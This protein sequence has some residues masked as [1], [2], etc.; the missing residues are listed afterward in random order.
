MY[1]VVDWIVMVLIES[2]PV[3]TLTNELVRDADTNI[4]NNMRRSVP[5]VTQ[6]IPIF[7]SLDGEIVRVGCVSTSFVIVTLHVLDCVDPEA[8]IS[9]NDP[10]TV[11]IESLNAILSVVDVA[12]PASPSCSGVLMMRPL[13]E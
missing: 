6:N 8:D 1:D 4:V 10:V 7:G 11:G 5:V 13:Y 12:Y 3:A 2:D 9:R